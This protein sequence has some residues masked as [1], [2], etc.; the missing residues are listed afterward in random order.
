[1]SIGYSRCLISF[2]SASSILSTSLFTISCLLFVDISYRN[3]SSPFP[4]PIVL[5]S[6]LLFLRL[7]FLLLFSCFLFFNLAPLFSTYTVF[8]FLISFN[9]SFPSFTFLYRRFSSIILKLYLYAYTS[10]QSSPQFPNLPHHVLQLFFRNFSVRTQFS[11]PSMVSRI[12]LR[13]IVGLLERAVNLSQR[14]YLHGITQRRETK[15]KHPCLKKDSN[16]RSTGRK[17][18]VQTLDRAARRSASYTC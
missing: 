8:Y 14:L 17:L 2:L 3:F 10:P 6:L 15:E 4:A 5:F 7:S 12:L 16:P 18:K 1:M 11:S 9:F 13:Y